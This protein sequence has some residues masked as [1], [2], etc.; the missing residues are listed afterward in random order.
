MKKFEAIEALKTA[1]PTKNT[2]KTE[3]RTKS[4]K[5]RRNLSPEAICFYTGLAM[6]LIENAFE[7]AAQ[8]KRNASSARRK[9][10]HRKLQRS[11]GKTV[12]VKR[13]GN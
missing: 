10:T 5:G 2:R 1:P 12:K 3:M 11:Q 8:A 13:Q 4:D 9:Q 6:G 7:Q